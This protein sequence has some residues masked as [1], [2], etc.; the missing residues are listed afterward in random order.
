MHLSIDTAAIRCFQP[1][2]LSLNIKHIA[3]EY[4]AH[5]KTV[6]AL[7]KRSIYSPEN[8]CYIRKIGLCFTQKYQLS[9]PNFIFWEK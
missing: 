2:C 1:Y 6:F 8:N 9:G 4:N 7:S 3:E 5:G